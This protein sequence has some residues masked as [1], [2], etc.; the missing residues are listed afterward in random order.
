MERLPI[1]TTQRLILSVP[2]LADAERVA[3]YHRENRAHLTPWEPTRPD[4]Y[5]T[6]E[7]WR[8]ALPDIAAEALQER[9]MAFILAPQSQPDA[10]VIGRCALT[11]IVRGPFQAAH[12][13]FSLA[14]TAVGHGYMFEA[15][16]AVIRFAFDELGL[17]RIMANYV[18]DNSR[19]ARVLAGLGFREEGLAR[20]YLFINGAWR[21]HIL[22]S[23]VNPKWRLA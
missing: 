22:T 1:L 23:L 8:G 19:S 10:P 6:T 16:S 21:D 17:H 3:A 12:L 20:D 14:Q 9:S 2:T 4:E 18:P 13:G 11:N 7:Y 5:F 15:L